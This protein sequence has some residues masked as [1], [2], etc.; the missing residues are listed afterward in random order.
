MV[1]RPEG[2]AVG[3]GRQ[4]LAAVQD[5]VLVPVEVDPVVPADP[6]F[7]IQGSG[8]HLVIGGARVHALG[9]LA[10]KAQDDGLVRTVAPA[11]GAEGT[12]QLGL[13]PR[14]GAQLPVAF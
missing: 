6:E 2:H 1:Q 10:L 9:V 7:G 5:H 3:V 8:C 14:G 13:H 12:E 11:G 4:G